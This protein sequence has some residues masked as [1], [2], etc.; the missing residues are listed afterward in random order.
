MEDN[1]Y[2]DEFEL[3]LKESADEFR[4][5]PSR[6]VWFS[7]YNNLHPDRRWPSMAVCL[8]IL[9]AVLYLGIANN[10]S[11]SN[12]AKKAS[13][14]NFSNILH[15]KNTGNTVTFSANDY[16]KPKDKKQQKF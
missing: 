9:T 5:V 12:A 7:L 1:N 14:E 15:E 4:M 2:K 16:I 11:L 13:S 3:F 6:K 10:N 8:L